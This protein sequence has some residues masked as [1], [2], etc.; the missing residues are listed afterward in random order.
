L[1][2]EAL[3]TETK[4]M[5]SEKTNGGGNEFTREVW[6]KKIYKEK[7]NCDRRDNAT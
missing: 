5:V 3:K 4:P 7:E 2:T 1:L 6:A